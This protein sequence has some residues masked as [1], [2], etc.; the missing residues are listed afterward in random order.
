VSRGIKALAAV[1]VVVVAVVLGLRA[2]RSDD[3]RTPAAGDTA[4]SGSER[5][6]PPP[7]YPDDMPAEGMYVDSTVTAD[8]LVEVET[9]IRSATPLS[10]LTLTTT[11]PDLAPGGVESLDVHVRTMTGRNLARR[12]SVGTNPQ[13]LR[14]NEPATELYFAYTVDGGLS[15]ASETVADRSL[16]RVLGMDVS[17]E[18]QAGPVHRVVHGPGTVI[19]VACLRPKPENDEDFNAS[20][21]PCGASTEDGGW[22]VDLTGANRGDRLLAQLEG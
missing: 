16:V 18:G 14:L 20:P 1:A 8:G 11:D 13:Q 6:G 12:D 21:R 22:A 7:A 15:D 10:E 17:Y 3:D 4:G 19:N 5:S 9:W 2:V